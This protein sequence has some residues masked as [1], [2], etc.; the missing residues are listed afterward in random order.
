[1]RNEP[2]GRVWMMASL[3][4]A[5]GGVVD[6]YLWKAVIFPSVTIIVAFSSSSSVSRLRE[7][8]MAPLKAR[9]GAMGLI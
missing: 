2:R 6:G 7:W 1:M 4:M 8:M 3:G 5:L 9:V